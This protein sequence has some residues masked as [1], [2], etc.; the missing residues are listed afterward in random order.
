MRLDI[1]IVGADVADMG[2]SK[3]DDLACVGRIHQDF[4]IAA[5]RGVEADLAQ[6]LTLSPQSQSPQHRAIAQN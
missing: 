1:L 2:K 3:G 4:L 6:R 5:H